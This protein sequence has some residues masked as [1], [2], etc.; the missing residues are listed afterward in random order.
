MSASAPF[1]LSLALRI[2][3]KRRLFVPLGNELLLQNERN[4]NN[5]LMKRADQ[6]DQRRRVLHAQLVDGTTKDASN[7]QTIPAKSTNA[8]EGRT[9]QQR[10]L[11]R[12]ADELVPQQ[13][14]HSWTLRDRDRF[15]PQ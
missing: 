12:I 9:H 3:L 15:E 11:L 6:E 10:A 5:H 13:I 1:G 14:L 4:S 8:S 7:K 2:V